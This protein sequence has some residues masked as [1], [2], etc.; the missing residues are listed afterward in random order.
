MPEFVLNGGHLPEFR[1][2]DSFV[3]GY[4]E[5][6]FFTENAPNVDMVKWEHLGESAGEIAEGR[7][8]SDCGFDDLAESTLAR[9]IA[10]C[11]AFQNAHREDLDELTDN[12]RS[13]GYDEESAGRDFWY[14]RNGHGCGYFDRT[15]FGEAA[16]RLQAACAW[17]GPFGEQDI[18]YGDDGKIYISGSENFKA[19]E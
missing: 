17:N 7:F 16:E 4:I 10:D 13:D 11:E 1:K 9:I 3:R 15:K 18:Y 5:A 6:L 2:L 14:S 19:G 12:G 8:P